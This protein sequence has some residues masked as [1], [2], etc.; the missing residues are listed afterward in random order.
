MG[1][2]IIQTP[3]GPVTIYSPDETYE[4]SVDPITTQIIN[5]GPNAKEINPQ[6]Y[7]TQDPVL[8]GGTGEYKYLLDPMDPA[9][10]YKALL[11]GALYPSDV[12][13]YENLTSSS[14]LTSGGP[15]NLLPTAEGAVTLGM[16][17]INPIFGML[18]RGA[19]SGRNAEALETLANQGILQTITPAKESSGFRKFMGYEYTP[20]TGE[21]RLSPEVELA[22]KQSGGTPKEYFESQYKSQYGDASALAQYLDQ[23]AYT[24]KGEFFQTDL[25][26]NPTAW[27]KYVDRSG[28][29]R[30]DALENW[31]KFGA[32][33]KLGALKYFK[34]KDQGTLAGSTNQ[35][36]IGGGEQISTPSQSSQGGKG[37]T[38]FKGPDGI[39]R[40]NYIGTGAKDD[41]GRTILSKTVRDNR[42]INSLKDRVSK[43]G[44]MGGV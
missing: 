2:K 38:L 24:T 18:T 15:F 43:R 9:G 35:G 19:I 13:N 26:G 27:S 25:F 34:K 44:G 28:K 31:K 11:S 5:R 30:P 20:G 17:Y 21:Y 1:T 16:G 6:G 8:G 3:S 41:K 10:A 39:M 40:E 33:D 4:P 23:I 29:I 22:I 36:T 32:E 42:G 37:P 14:P 12:N 7:F